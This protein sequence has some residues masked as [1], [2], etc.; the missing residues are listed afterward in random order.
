M[1]EEYNIS[2]AEVVRIAVRMLDDKERAKF[3][4]PQLQKKK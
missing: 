4:I 1:S 3:P 2:E